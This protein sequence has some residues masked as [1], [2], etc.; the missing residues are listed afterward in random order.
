VTAT[1]PDVLIICDDPSHGGKV[2]TIEQMVHD[3]RWWIGMGSISLKAKRDAPEG[4]TP[5]WSPT[6]SAETDEAGDAYLKHRWRCSCD[7]DVKARSAQA[8]PI[9]DGLAANGVPTIS[10][11]SLASRLGSIERKQ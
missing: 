11:R 9:F 5:E 2:V 7:L 6:W 1:L 4:A 3:G 8:D 10:L